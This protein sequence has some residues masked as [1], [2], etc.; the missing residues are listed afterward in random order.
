[1]VLHRRL[2]MHMVIRLLHVRLILMLLRNHKL[3]LLMLLLRLESRHRFAFP[4]DIRGIQSSSSGGSGR[5]CVARA[6]HRCGCLCR[7]ATGKRRRSRRRSEC[8]GH[9]R[10]RQIMHAAKPTADTRSAAATCTIAAPA[11]VKVARRQIR[12]GKS[13]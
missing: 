7:E 8:C 12:A 13:R 4:T 6:Q 9:R 10:A 2:H 1:V 11:C 3:L 5:E